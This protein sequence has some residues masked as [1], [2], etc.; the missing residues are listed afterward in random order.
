MEFGRR[1]LSGYM[2]GGSVES[3]VALDAAGTLQ[4][5]MPRTLRY[6]R[7]SPSL[8]VTLPCGS[9]IDVLVERIAPDDPTVG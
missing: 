8:D 4:E 7:G 5:G 1:V 2:P 3:D 9:G 6:G